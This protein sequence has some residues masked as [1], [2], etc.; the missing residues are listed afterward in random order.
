M[1]DHKKDDEPFNEKADSSEP[2]QKESL[3]TDVPPENI[4]D[5]TL[6]TSEDSDVVAE[7]DTTVPVIPMRD[8]VIF[9]NAV[10]PLLVGRPKSVSA[11]MHAIANN[12]KI[13]LVMQ[14]RGDIDDAQI[15]D[16][17]KVGVFGTI[18]HYYRL[19][20]DTLKIMVDTTTRAEVLEYHNTGKF[21]EAKIKCIEIEVE[22]SPE[23]QALMRTTMSCMQEY[24]E[25]SKHIGGDVLTF[26]QRISEPN[27][28]ADIT[29][30]YFNIASKQKQEI[31]ETFAIVP[32]LEKIIMI[33]MSEVGILRAE[34]EVQKRLKGQVNK[35]H[36]EYY[37]NE[38]IKAIRSE[39]GHGDDLT[40]SIERYQ[41]M[42]KN[43]PLSPEAY[44]KAQEEIKRLSSSVS[45]S[46]ENIRSYL[47]WIFG[48]PW[49]KYDK[50]NHDLNNAES[51]LHQSHYGLNEVKESILEYL[52][53]QINKSNAHSPILC[54]YGPPGVGKTTL[55]RTIAQA[56]GR[57]YTK[58]SL[59]GMRDEAE[60]RGHRRTYIGALPGK[61][62]QAMK[63]VA[64]C[65]PVILLDEIDKISGDYRGDPS[66]A[67]LEALDPEQN[68]DFSDYYLEVGFDLSKVMFVATANGLN[69]IQR[70]LLDRLEIIKVS[71]YLEQDKLQICKNYII[72]KQMSNTGLN[73]DLVT[74]SD[75][76]IN[77]II[78]YY[79]RESGVRELDRLVG[80]IMRK[81][82]MRIIKSNACILQYADD[83]QQTTAHEQ[84]PSETEKEQIV[85]KTLMENAIMHHAEGKNN[86]E[87]VR[88]RITPCNLQDYLGVKKYSHNEVEH[89]NLIGVTNG[90]AY[91][92]VGGDVLLIEGVKIPGG[93]G[94]LKITGSLGEVM[95]ESVHASFSYIKAQ[96]KQLNIEVADMYNHDI[97]IH[98]PEGATPKDGPSA[99]VTICTTMASLL[100]NR[101]VR[102]DIAMTGEI[103]L[104]GRVL[105]IGGLREKMVSALRCSI[106][107]VIIPKDNQKDLEELPNDIKKQLNVLFCDSVAEVL[108]IA[109]VANDIED[110]MTNTLPLQQSCVTPLEIMQHAP[111]CDKATTGF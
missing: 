58:I 61:I 60:I 25:L 28:L 72:K 106:K 98:I 81:C 37:L 17:E 54:L 102:R 79:T 93:K 56:M 71:S 63:K 95:K 20:D 43:K 4:T 64:T 76:A 67:L 74:I 31:L 62:I 75:K 27:M 111:Y 12:Q 14:K 88:T 7:L 48:L 108:E 16:L 22:D 99:G 8:T 68:K 23:V 41:E 26:L 103:T 47:D 57:K 70:P 1:T 59:G 105:K 50:C 24:A 110:V 44:A 29:M 97:H 6:N 83:D 38:Q 15:E 96:H 11:V 101:P 73:D 84:A 82:L 5:D 78:K 13:F 19:P 46:T 85:T 53:V 36:K 9:P 87:I 80:K 33:A 104:R 91:T 66:S 30:S 10:S 21:L 34:Q 51:I 32:R 55:V 109:L 92:E 77:D 2:S 100:T 86:I 35:N 90:L 49:Y 45:M 3:T 40:D 89:I 39:L 107:N 18:A 42:L 65:N 69:N 52:A 94:E